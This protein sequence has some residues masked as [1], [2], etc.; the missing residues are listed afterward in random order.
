MF[1]WLYDGKRRKLGGKAIE[2]GKVYIRTQHRTEG[3]NAGFMR[4]PF[5]G[6]IV[7]N[8]TGKL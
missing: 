6:Y 5:M 8:E 2:V 3:R 7:P 4:A 1:A